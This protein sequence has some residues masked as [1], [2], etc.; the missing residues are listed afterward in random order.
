MSSPPG[1]GERGMLPRMDRNAIGENIRALRLARGYTLREAA[2][3]CGVQFT[4]LNQIEGGSNTTLETLEKVVTGLGGV[5]EV[6]IRDL[7][8]A[9]LPATPKVPLHRQGIAHRLLSILP[10]IPDDEM[11][12]LLAQVA[13]WERRYGRSSNSDT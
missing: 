9:V 4:T 6:E 8:D 2:P 12:V 5:V 13:L 1:H 7:R 3:R 10:H 11:D